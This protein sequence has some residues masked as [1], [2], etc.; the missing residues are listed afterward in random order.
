MMERKKFE[1]LT[2]DKI[3]S[4]WSNKQDIVLS[5]ICV[6]FN[7]AK[8]VEEAIRGFLIQK[9]D[10]AFEVIIHD[11]AST[12]KTVDIIKRYQSLYPRIIKPIF[13]TENQYSKGNFR[14][15]LY[16]ST[17]A[18]GEFIARCEGDDYWVDPLKIITQVEFLQQNKEYVITYTDSIAI[19]NNGLTGVNYGGAT[20]DLSKSDLKKA[21]PIYTLTSCYRN[22]LKVLP[23]EIM[24]APIGDM[25]YWSLLGEYGKGKFLVQIEP[26]I[27]RV[28]DGG[29]L[30]NK[31]IEKKAAM[32]AK[33][34][35]LLYMYHSGKNDEEI[36]RYYRLEVIARLLY[37]PYK[38]LIKQKQR[39]FMK[40]M[41]KV[42]RFI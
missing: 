17:F 23:P 37:Y 8:F 42:F 31:P 38:N 33:T 21:A 35:L 5:I 40:V 32:L 24:L 27:Y 30:S 3:I 22:V 1:L 10:F 20:K 13:Q 2:E 34:L 15:V 19:D 7:H 11:D 12:D 36:T 28:H 29:I 18:K 25:F 16:A 4:T 6:T 26:S 9:T 14:P 41:L 39:F